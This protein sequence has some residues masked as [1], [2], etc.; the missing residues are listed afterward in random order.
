MEVEPEWRRSVGL[1]DSQRRRIEMPVPRVTR[2]GGRERGDVRQVEGRDH[3]MADVRPGMPRK[4][5][6]PGFDRVEGL[7]NSD[8]PAGRN[9]PLGAAELL[10]GVFRC[11][12]HDN[13]RRGQ[14]A[15]ADQFG[16]QLLQRLVDLFGFCDGVRIGEGRRFLGQHLLDQRAHRLVLGKPEPAPFDQF[17]LRLLAIEAQVAGHPAIGHR[18]GVEVIEHAGMGEGREA[19]DREHAEMFRAQHRRDTADEWGVA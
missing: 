18:G 11:Y 15:E 2:P 4:A 7:G 3:G 12:S 17:A 5:R 14:E 6:Q 8:K 9:D 10:I 19:L 16:A 13:Q 1:R